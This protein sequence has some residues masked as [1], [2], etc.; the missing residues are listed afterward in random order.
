MCVAPTYYGDRRLLLW[1]AVLAV[2]LWLVVLGEYLLL[3]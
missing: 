2:V 3:S 1:L